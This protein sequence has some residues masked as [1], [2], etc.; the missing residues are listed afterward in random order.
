[1]LHGFLILAWAIGGC[2]LFGRVSIFGRCAIGR[3]A[4]GPT[5]AWLARGWFGM[6]VVW[7]VGD[8]FL[9]ECLVCLRA[10][11]MLLLQL[12]IYAAWFPD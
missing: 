11:E 4:I 3:C 8:V 1:M 10:S 9:R 5:L 7:N 2:A 12:L 6:W